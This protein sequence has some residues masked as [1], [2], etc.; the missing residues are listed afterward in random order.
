MEKLN[1]NI[2]YQSIEKENY[3]TLIDHLR[4]DLTNRKI[5]FSYTKD[6]KIDQQQFDIFYQQTY[7]DPTQK[8]CCPIFRWSCKKI[9]SGVL[10]LFWYGSLNNFPQFF[11]S[12]FNIMFLAKEILGGALSCKSIDWRNLRW[13]QKDLYSLVRNLQVAGAHLLTIVNDKAG[14]YYLDAFLF[15]KYCLENRRSGHINNWYEKSDQFV[16]LLASEHPSYEK[17]ECIVHQIDKPNPKKDQ[18][19]S[20]KECI[21]EALTKKFGWLSKALHKDNNQT[22]E[23]PKLKELIEQFNEII[24][25]YESKVEEIEKEKWEK[26]IKEQKSYWRTNFF[27]TFKGKKDVIFEFDALNDAED[28]QAYFEL[29]ARIR[30]FDFFSCYYNKINVDHRKD[31]LKGWITALPYQVDKKSVHER[32]STDTSY[33]L[34]K[35]WKPEDKYDSHHAEILADFAKDIFRMM[36]KVKGITKDDFRLFVCS[37]TERLKP[38]FNTIKQIDDQIKNAYLFFEKNPDYLEY[39]IDITGQ[40]PNNWLI[41]EPQTNWYV[42]LFKAL[43]FK[44]PTVFWGFLQAT[45]NGSDNVS[46]YN[47][48]AEEIVDLNL[49]LKIFGYPS[50]D[51]T[52][53]NPVVY[54]YFLKNLDN[55]LENLQKNESQQNPEKKQ[56]QGNINYKNKIL[57]TK[58]KCEKQRLPLDIFMKIFPKP[59]FYK[60]L[61][62]CL[63]FHKMNIKL[64][65]P[66]MWQ[67]FSLAFGFK[68]IQLT[69]DSKDSEIKF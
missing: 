31:F 14:R 41:L 63:T 26:I 13:L 67:I 8:D 19:P 48:L 23:M 2:F 10:A 11:R 32:S 56:I 51:K 16:D 15:E 36:E 28:R 21:D 1:N 62:C 22:F 34:K 3:S 45:K 29:F 59:E 7:V 4:N 58:Q 18:M 47:D 20:V 64:P 60:F 65:K 52:L 61:T 33:K 17:K 44:K 35:E 68:N 66:L 53:G 46:F 39:T 55:H 57:S 27:M 40:T 49:K 43:T 6:A 42:S 38:D 50:D 69:I 54:Y 9:S 25:M 37:C 12:V 30:S 24:S 5:R